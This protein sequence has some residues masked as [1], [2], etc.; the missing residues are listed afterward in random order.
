MATVIPLR[1]VIGPRSDEGLFPVRVSA[2]DEVLDAE[3]TLPEALLEIGERLL[4]PHAHVAAGSV[5][6]IGRQLG[7][8]LFTPRLRG[9]LLEQAKVAAQER[10]RLQI[11]LQ[12]AVPE[13]AALPWEW[14]S[15]GASRPW[16]PALRD[17]YT[18]VR[19]G[20]QARPAA[21]ISVTGPLRILAVGGAGQRAQ[22][23][24][25]EDTMTD[26]VRDRRVVLRLLPDTDQD[27]IERMLSREQFHVLHCAVPAELTADERLVLRLGR[28]IEGFDLAD[29][30]AEHPTLR[31]VMLMGGEG[32][33]SELS[34]VTPLMGAVLMGNHVP[35]AVTLAS[36]LSADAAAAFAAVCYDDLAAGDPLDLAVTSARRMLAESEPGAWGMPQLRM[37]PGAEHLF[38]FRN[39]K[40]APNPR[41]LL[42]FAI[43]AA[44][45]VALLLAGRMLTARGAGSNVDRGVPGGTATAA[46]GFQMPA[47]PG[48]PPTNTPL[49]QAPTPT[50]LPAPL[51]FTTYTVGVSDTLD[52]I[53]LRFGSD[54]RG[55]AELNLL[56][57]D[58]ALREGRGLVIPVYHDGATETGG[59][60]VQRLDAAQR[61]VALTFDIEI[62]D[63]SV[64]TIL[65]ALRA[66]GVK[67]T[68]FVTGRWVMAFPDAARAIVRDGHELGN[69]SL[70]HPYFSRIGYD[71]AASE[72]DETERIV[73][74]T[75]G[76]T[77]RPYFRFPYGDSTADMVALVA[78][79][80]Y[81]AYHWSVDDGAIDGWI[82]NAVEDPDS[83]DGAI[84]LMH[85]RTGTAE[86]VGGWVDELIAAGLHPTTLSEAL[87]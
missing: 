48:A 59:L 3:L 37:L 9:L 17:D 26:L 25:L 44:L 4:A 85:G 69:H 30:L 16:V 75:T 6:T 18:L 87:R 65:D 82:A 46:P 8:A 52:V 5:E 50:A 53:A 43:A 27:E 51:S 47:F 36:S 7:R 63:K 81:I 32:D 61:N 35:A 15:I 58:D 74:E 49:E 22:L 78:R 31:L 20:R 67:G 71:G 79:H 68:F 39:A 42:P 76:A 40:P 73:R 28:G 38:V 1:I 86:K 55:I 11:Q 60:I 12:I 83:A 72:L 56:G 45:L 33:G 29:L 34:A 24:A 19:V 14:L 21:P 10:A 62:D 66:R 23:D 77:T 57:S 84:V 54:P 70:T 41:R 80:G 2:G 64:Y 13:V